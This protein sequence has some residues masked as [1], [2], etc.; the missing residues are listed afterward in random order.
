MTNKRLLKLLRGVLIEIEDCRDID[1][2]LNEIEMTQE[3][4][5]YVLENGKEIEI[6]FD[7]LSKIK[8]IKIRND[9][10]YFK[11]YGSPTKMMIIQP[12]KKTISLFCLSDYDNEELK[13]D[14]AIIKPL[15]YQVNEVLK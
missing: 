14:L 3:E 1:I 11:T 13:N 8:D 15:C 5:D 6:V 10:V 7:T 9:G 4:Y 2:V 12:K